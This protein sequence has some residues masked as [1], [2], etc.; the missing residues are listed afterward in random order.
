MFFSHVFP[1]LF[2]LTQAALPLGGI[3]PDEARRLLEAERKGN[4]QGV[5][6]DVVQFPHNFALE[7]AYI[8]E[9]FVK[10]SEE[11]AKQ[12]LDLY[13][14]GS[15]SL[16]LAVSY[17]QRNTTYGSQLWTILI[18]HCLT[19]VQDG[20][21]FG[22][23]LE[24][25]AQCGADLGHLV[26]QIP[27]GMQIEGLR[28]RLVAAVAD[29][30]WKLKMHEAASIIGTT[31]RIVLLRELAHRSKRGMRVSKLAAESEA[32]YSLP[33]PASPERKPSKSTMLKV[34]TIPNR[35]L[36]RPNRYRLSLAVPIR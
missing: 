16:M 6:S 23:L 21:L 7:L 34:A 25:A 26:T 2:I 18:D 13:L 22:S 5:Q 24:C 3:R 15:E 28:P 9:N 20:S 4:V 33:P 11:D 12:I 29:Y 19:S 17:A 8:F 36:E 1:S 31:E 27:Q 30:R 35:P 14:N 32:R 10:G